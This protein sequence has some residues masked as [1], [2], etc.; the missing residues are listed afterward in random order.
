MIRRRVWRRGSAG[1]RG[2]IAVTV[3][4]LLASGVLFGFG[5]LVVD[6]GTIYSERRELQTSA[7][8][9]AL[10]LAQECARNGPGCIATSSIP[11]TYANAN[12]S[13]GVT[14]VDSVC[15]RTDGSSCGGTGTTLT[16]CLPLPA[17][18][19]HYVEVRTSTRTTSGK[20]VLPPVF[21]QTLAGGPGDGNVR[22]CSRAA[23]GPPQGNSGLSV[24]LSICEWNDGTG[25]GTAYFTGPTPYLGAGEPGGPNPP[26][27][28]ELVI[29]LHTTTTTTCPKG[30]AGSNAPG[31]FGWLDETG[32]P[33]QASVTSGGTTGGNP[34]AP[35][36]QACKDALNQAYTDRKPLALPVFD[37]VTGTGS[38]TTYHIAGISEFVVTGYNLPGAKQD[39][40]LT[41]GTPSSKYCKGSDKCIYGF[42][43]TG[44]LPVTGT[45]GGSGSDFGA[46]IV[47]LI[48]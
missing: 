35:P 33:C 22:A 5:A 42:F 24:T 18:V 26:P 10:A 32:G 23:W 4:L 28:Y 14:N 39:S 6:V 19:T 3:A 29:M 47:Q 37:Q 8:A 11:A 43:T 13:D 45:I 40:W 12:A 34:G 41:G 9:G 21:A 48:G 17:G 2:A 25:G 46:S 20:T 31:G 7:D 27:S 36:S 38:G 44:L 30:P 1:E 15:I 16:N